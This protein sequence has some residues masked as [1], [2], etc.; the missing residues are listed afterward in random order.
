MKPLNP[1]PNRNPNQVGRIVLDEPSSFV[2]PPL[3]GQGSHPSNNPVIPQSLRFS[4]CHS[5][6]SVLSVLTLALLCSACK[7]TRFEYTK[8]GVTIRAT[9]TRFLLRSNAKITVE[10]QTNN[11]P[12]L[13]VEAESSVEAQAFQAFGR[14]LAEGLKK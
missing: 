12:R 11:Y 1:N 13:S 14:G 5:V 4:P 3:G 6:F 8:D 2:V 10:P 7:L 9:D